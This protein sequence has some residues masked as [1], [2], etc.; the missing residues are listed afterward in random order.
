MHRLK[1]TPHFLIVDYGEMWISTAKG[2]V[3]P[4]M[5]SPVDRATTAFYSCFVDKYCL[6][7][8]VS[9]LL[10]P[11]SH[12]EKWQKDDFG[13]YGACLI[14]SDITSRFPNP[15]LVL[16]VFGI[17]RPSLNDQNLFNIFDLHAKCPLKIREKGYSPVK[18]FFH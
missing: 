11:F 7:C 2:R 6:S 5:R 18:N 1:V 9:T 4:E 3:R 12:C 17:L 10:A 14:G 8:N 13:R 16:I 15:D